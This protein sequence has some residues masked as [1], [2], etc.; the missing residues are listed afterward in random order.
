MSSYSNP[1][2][3]L[4][5]LFFQMDYDQMNNGSVGNNP[6]AASYLPEGSPVLPTAVYNST[7]A[8]RA[9]GSQALAQHAANGVFHLGTSSPHHHHHHHHTLL[10]AA[11]NTNNPSPGG[12]TYSPA[13]AT[14]QYY[15]NT[16]AG[17]SY[18]SGG[19]SSYGGSA[20][21]VGAA[22]SDTTSA[23][24]QMA[25]A[26]YE[27]IPMRQAGSSSRRQPPPRE[28]NRSL[29]D[30]IFGP[31]GFLNPVS[32]TPPLSTSS[33]ANSYDPLAIGHDALY[34]GRKDQSHARNKNEEL[35]EEIS[36]QVPSLSL[37]PISGNEIVR[38]IRSCISDVTQRYIPCVDFLV[39][40]QQE[41]RKGL[42]AAQKQQ[43]TGSSRRYYQSS[44]TPRQFWQSYI[45]NLPNRFY[46][47]NQR[48]MVHEP[49]QEAVQG[50]HKLRSE[51]KHACTQG[52]E[53]VKNTFLGG[54]KEGESWG[55]RKWLSKNG[56]ALRVCTDLE[57]ILRACKGL[58]KSKESTKKLAA[59]LRP[60]SK[61]TLD[62]LKKD[63]PP[64]YQERSSAHPYLPFFHRL[65]A[66]LRA[67][68]QFD[69]EDDEIICLDDSDD[70]DD[71]VLVEIAPPKVASRKRKAKVEVLAVDTSP[72][73]K[74]VFDMK[75]ATE[76]VEEAK[77]S[78]SQL[79]I[80]VD[81]D[82]SSSGESEAYSL[83]EIV[84]A[85]AAD[86][87]EE[88]KGE[89]RGGGVHSE[90]RCTNCSHRNAASAHSVCESCGEPSYSDLMGALGFSPS[91]LDD[92]WGDDL[93]L[94]SVDSPEP[95]RKKQ[96][97][98][99]KPRTNGH[100]DLSHRW[101][102]EV[103]HDEMNTA[104]ADAQ[105]LANKADKLALMF[106]G[107][108]HSDLPAE[109]LRARKDLDLWDDLYATA[110]RIFS[111]VLRQPDAI[112]FVGAIND[113]E[114]VKA[115]HPP[116]GSV[117]KHPLCFNEI[118]TSLVDLDHMDDEHSGG[119]RWFNGILS[120]RGLSQWN[121]WRGSALIQ[122]IDLVFLN[123]LA[124]SKSCGEGRSR[125]RSRTNGLRKHFWDQIYDTVGAYCDDADQRRKST[126]TRRSEGSG[127]VVYKATKL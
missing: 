73:V 60:I 54:M 75:V 112:H 120:R 45:E 79:T 58:D 117:V 18:S 56:N 36:L 84:G 37:E 126:P 67:M 70:D 61:E 9:A 69:P 96:K 72:P 33:S 2:G 92:K 77:P 104:L 95:V 107:M 51:S 47:S 29:E 39:Q 16:A 116:Y 46:I 121:M 17:N 43:R 6:S 98:E 15:T 13:A 20:A 124:Y 23:L 88:T 12:T 50:L 31:N 103:S 125:H 118:L 97:M 10:T 76:I 106:D 110:L 25:A 19:M 119:Y 94:S 100:K 65:E 82:D 59:L 22:A 11:M 111:D 38:R 123:S 1:L 113:Y 78:E 44:M 21:N 24:Q 26:A 109:M 52:S 5:E 86:D 63:V 83:I 115:G 102:I 122:A 3:G 85:M 30:L 87:Q 42:Q 48:R 90:W 41:L 28:Q 93:E 55:L 81:D 62:R 127:F 53:A 114:L 68:S 99:A 35:F 80:P 32:S 14:A 105:I 8:T 89:S 64:S 34:A 49:L 74:R 108:S 57:C 71:P 66:A 91:S 40:C 27:P 4:D 101:P 7:A